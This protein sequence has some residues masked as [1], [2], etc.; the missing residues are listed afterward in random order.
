MKPAAP[1]LRL[2]YKDLLVFPEDD[3]KRHELIDGVHYVTATPNV[4]HQT[5]LMNLAAMLLPYLRQHPIGRLF[6]VPLDI[7]LSDVDV[8]EPDLQFISRQREREILNEQHVRGAPDLVAEVASPSTRKRDATI[9]KRAY[10]RYGVSEYWVI[11]PLGD[12]ITV[13]RLVDSRYDQVAELSAENDDVL[14]TPLF[15]GLE[16]PLSEVFMT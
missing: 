16:L 9:K 13:Y 10:E 15:P 6:N 14:T 4:K 7:V 2:T 5:I 3:G 11:D 1:G 12:S 8:L